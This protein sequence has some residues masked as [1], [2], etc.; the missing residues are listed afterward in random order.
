MLEQI[1]RIDDGVLPSSS[2]TKRA[3]GGTGKPG[4]SAATTFWSF[5]RD[6]LPCSAMHL[7]RLPGR[8]M[9]AA[10]AMTI[11]TMPPI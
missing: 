4:R 5:S 3:S 1:N 7:I 2:I 9:M 6:W 8:F 10:S 11:G